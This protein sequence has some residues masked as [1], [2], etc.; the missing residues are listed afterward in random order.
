MAGLPWVGSGGGKPDASKQFAPKPG[1]RYNPPDPAREPGQATHEGTP[2]D[3]WLAPF[4]PATQGGPN[5]GGQFFKQG[6]GPR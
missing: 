1:T 4:P 6:P 3:E 2:T 5:S